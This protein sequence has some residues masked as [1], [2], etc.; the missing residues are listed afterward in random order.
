MKAYDLQ[1]ALEELSTERL[2]ALVDR[3]GSGSVSEVTVGA[4][5]PQCPMLLAGFE[6]TRA[7]ANTPE[8]HFASIWD[9]FA[10]A[11][12]TPLWRRLRV[13]QGLPASD[14]DVQVLLRMTNA[15]LA[16]RTQPPD[17]LWP[18]SPI[19]SG[20]RAGKPGAERKP[21]AERLA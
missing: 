16:A 15:V 19:L 11:C 18:A 12:P 10:T 3:L 6:P 21:R 5:R 7:A 14:R 17:V 13:R 1:I 2:Q 4:W 9:G 8:G 20:D